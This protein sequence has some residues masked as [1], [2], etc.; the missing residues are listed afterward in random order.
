VDEQQS[1]RIITNILDSAQTKSSDLGLPVGPV[2]KNLPSNAGDMGS[3][4]GQGS[5]NN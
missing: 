5:K 3:N 1:G 2:V 4:P